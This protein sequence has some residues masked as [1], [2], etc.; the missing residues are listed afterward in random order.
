[1]E[2]TL[3]IVGTAGRKDD[4][5]KLNSDT[6]KAMCLVA[7][8]LMK[9]IS[10]SNYPITHLISG[11]AA[12]TDHCA[13]RLFLDKKVPNL[14]L[15]IPAE[16]DNGHFHDNGIEKDPIKNPGGTANYYHKLFQNKTFI[17]SL[18]EIQVAKAYGAELLTC[19][20]GFH[21]RNAMVAKS[22]FI[23]ACTFGDG[24][25][26]KDGGTADTVRKYLHRVRKEGIFDKSFHYCLTDG[27][28]HEGCQVPEEEEKSLEPN[29]T[30]N[31]KKLHY[32]QKR[33][34]RQGF[35]GYPWASPP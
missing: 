35:G 14:R 16:W 29:S 15:F 24:P 1:M 34:Q 28:I 6:F 33:T 7:E 3:A 30:V 12:W 11:G 21:G 23:L 31:F 32:L 13:V 2:I 4:S 22:D 8:G 27:T 10:E 25:M 20:G 9:Q 26:L 5:K 19:R 17:N 18:S